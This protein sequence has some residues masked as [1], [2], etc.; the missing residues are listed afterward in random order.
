MSENPEE[1]AEV[2]NNLTRIEVPTT[3][4]EDVNSDKSSSPVNDDCDLENNYLENLR[5]PGSGDNQ[6]SDDEE[7]TE[8]ISDFIN[9]LSVLVKPNDELEKP[10]ACQ[11]GEGHDNASVDT[12]ATTEPLEQSSAKDE[13]NI[14]IDSGVVADVPCQEDTFKMPDSFDI[15]SDYIN[16]ILPT[17]SLS[18]EVPNDSSP[19]KNLRKTSANQNAVVKK[20]EPVLP[21]KSAEG[22]GKLN[23]DEIFRDDMLDNDNRPVQDEVVA[24]VHLKA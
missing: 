7:T 9:Q 20:Q 15:P 14:K 18:L 19:I 10:D 13:E 5:S 12:T 1:A 8:Q 21:N 2:Q 3:T 16:E 22:G 11:F 17:K 4:T 6:D 23:F 24:L